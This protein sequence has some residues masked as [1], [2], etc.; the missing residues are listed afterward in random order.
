M[1]MLVLLLVKSF[2]LFSSGM[3]WQGEKATYD[4]HFES[5]IYVSQAHAQL[6]NQK[7]YQEHVFQQTSVNGI[8]GPLRSHKTV[9]ESDCTRLSSCR[10]AKQKPHFQTKQ[11]CYTMLPKVL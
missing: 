10:G 7:M 4:V 1:H 5:H 9:V 2:A 8:V 3:N 6:G 11:R